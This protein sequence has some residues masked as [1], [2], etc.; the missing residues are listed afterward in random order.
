[1]DTGPGRPARTEPVVTGRP[2]PSAERI[3]ECRYVVATSGPHDYVWVGVSADLLAAL[4][5]ATD[6]ADEQF[7][8][9][10]KAQARSSAYDAGLEDAAKHLASFCQHQ[11][12]GEPCGECDDCINAASIR[13]LKGGGA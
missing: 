12:L 8:I 1:M 10:T 4:D 6:L 9:R 5:A 7:K 3:A 2:A 13:A 11:D